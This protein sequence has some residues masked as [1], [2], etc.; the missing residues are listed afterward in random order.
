MAM[1]EKSFRA[2]LSAIIL[3]AIDDCGGG[4]SVP[5]GE[6]DRAMAWVHSPDCERLCF[7]LDV[8][9]EQVKEKAAASYRR[10]FSGSADR[11]S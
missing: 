1:Q 9:W 4:L 11:A 10:S 8:Q 2:L 6:E 5:F 3:R 7:A